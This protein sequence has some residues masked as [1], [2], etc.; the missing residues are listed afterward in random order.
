MCWRLKSTASG[1]SKMPPNSKN[2]IAN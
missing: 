1:G 2:C